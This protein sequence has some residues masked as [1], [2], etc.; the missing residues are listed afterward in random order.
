MN[1]ERIA[2]MN[3]C[4]SVSHLRDRDWKKATLAWSFCILLFFFFFCLDLRWVIWVI[5]SSYK[6]NLACLQRIP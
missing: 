3:I 4:I 5:E 2:F 1:K 6:N